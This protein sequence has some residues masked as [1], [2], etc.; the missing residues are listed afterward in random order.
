MNEIVPTKIS[1]C[2]YWRLQRRLSQLCV[3]NKK[4]KERKEKEKKKKR[5]RERERER[6]KRERDVS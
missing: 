3:S 2:F 1:W 6:G 5:E 4:K